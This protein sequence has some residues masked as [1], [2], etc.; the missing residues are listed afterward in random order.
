M[1]GFVILKRD[2]TKGE[3]YKSDNVIRVYLH[4]LIK[5]NY[6]NKKWQGIVIK[7]G[8]LVTSLDHLSEEIGIS[9]SKVRTALKKLEKSKHILKDSTNK[10]SVITIIDYSK[11]QIYESSIDKQKPFKQQ[12][13]NNQLTTTNKRNHL[14]NLKNNIISL[15]R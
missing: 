5:A 4:L 14:N 7:R 10:Y 2:I 11:T 3:W 12:T 9:V 8:Q 15:N 13:N 6:T 1:R